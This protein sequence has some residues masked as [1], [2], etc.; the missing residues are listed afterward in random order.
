MLL[1]FFE[2]VQKFIPGER[3]QATGWLVQ[4]QHFR[5]VGKSHEKVEIDLPL[6]K[7]AI[8][9]IIAQNQSK[10]ITPELVMEVVA[11][12]YNVPVDDIK[13]SKRNREIA[14]PR[15]VIMYLCRKLTDCPLKSIGIAVG[16]KDHSTIS[17]GIEKI[18][19]ELKVDES[20]KND[21]Q[22]L[23]KKIRAL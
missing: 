7:M 9:D 20:L 23:T 14:V 8:K 19:K 12:H 5:L 18:E 10:M 15:Q 3:I 2:N 16:G 17:H 13:S 1:Q 11:D 6:T 21:I 4:D 22:I